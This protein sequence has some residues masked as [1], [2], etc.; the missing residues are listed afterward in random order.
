MT[1]LIAMGTYT[2]NWFAVCFRFFQF[3]SVST[4]SISFN[5]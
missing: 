3:I 1:L 2:M 4:T 5:L